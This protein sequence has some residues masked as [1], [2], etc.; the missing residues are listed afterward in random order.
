MSSQEAEELVEEQALKF[1]ER[2]DYLI[3]IWDEKSAQASR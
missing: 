1:E 3:R 2:K